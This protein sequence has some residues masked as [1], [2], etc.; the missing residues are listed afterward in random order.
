MNLSNDY[1]SNLIFL[2]Q[3]CPCEAVVN[4]ESSTD[5]GEQ[6]CPIC[7]KTFTTQEVGIPDCCT[8]TFCFTCLH[9]WAE[10]IVKFK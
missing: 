5:G 2:I 3:V 8:H 9:E 7:L 1:A 6:K 4:V 10:E